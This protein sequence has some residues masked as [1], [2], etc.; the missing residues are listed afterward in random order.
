MPLAFG[1]PRHYTVSRKS[2]HR[3]LGPNF[4]E[5]RKPPGPR[6]TWSYPEPVPP[7]GIIGSSVF[8]LGGPR[9]DHGVADLSFQAPFRHCRTGR[10]GRFLR[11]RRL[12]LA[13]ATRRRR[14]T[15]RRQTESF[16]HVYHPSTSLKYCG[17][18]ITDSG[19]PWSASPSLLVSSRQLA[20]RSGAALLPA[21][22]HARSAA[23]VSTPQRR[24]RHGQSQAL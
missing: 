6:R 23:A 2:A 15:A 10:C 5:G 12:V 19:R 17:G 22:M 18:M 1:S 8:S 20:G 21:G 13:D 24:H 9:S 7:D 14:P 11:R 3:A 16:L 4:Q